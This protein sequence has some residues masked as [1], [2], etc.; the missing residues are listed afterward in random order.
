MAFDQMSDIDSKFI[1]DIT[2]DIILGKIEKS[3]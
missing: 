1:S 3:Y 2:E